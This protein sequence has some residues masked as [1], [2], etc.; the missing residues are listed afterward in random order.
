VSWPLSNDLLLA[1]PVL[2]PLT[3]GVLCALLWS[4]PGAQALVSLLGSAALLASALALSRRVWS[5]GVLATQGGDW[6]AP[7][8]I[9]LVADGLACVM[10][11]IA[12]GTALATSLHAVGSVGDWIRRG[13]FFPL[14]HTLL[15]GVC[16]AFL[17]GDVFN[18]YVWYEV[19]LVS[20]FVLLTLGG[21]RP[22]LEGGLKYLV[23]NLF[24][25]GLF[26]AGV[27]IIYA[28]AGTL[29]MAHLAERF[30]A[31]R[32]PLATAS[33]VLILL[34][35]LMKAAAAPMFFWLPASYPA[36]PPV[37]AALFAGLLSKVGVYSA[38]RTSALF[39]GAEAE[40]VFGA[41]T[42][43]AGATMVLGVFGAAVQVEIRRILA[44][45]SVSQIGYMLMGVGVGLLAAREARALEGLDPSR[46][47]ALRSAAELALAGAVI[48]LVHHAVI[49]GNLFLI[50]GAILR[51]RGT[52][53]L[54]ELGGLVRTRPGLAALFFLTSMSL[55]GIP[56]LSGFV[57]KLALVKAGLQAAQGWVVG[58]ALFT[59]I[60]TLY[61]MVKIWNEAFLKP[62][63]EQPPRPM[64]FARDR[65]TGRPAADGLLMGV[66]IAALAGLGVLMGLLPGP[67]LDLARRAARDVLDP[68]AYT[69]AVLTPPADGARPGVPTARAPRS[70]Q[71][72][73][74]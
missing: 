39:A 11:L 34:A 29:N 26:L 14:V 44:F 6:P 22:Q 61:S 27:G 31:E 10:L 56:L 55:A 60:L 25:S 74:P 7:W 54:A 38:L 64:P 17:T 30:A 65:A 33:G 48:F 71:G 1:L 18:M 21:T 12:G 35:F 13:P 16:G 8:G 36:A 73:V 66:P 49:K 3:T 37:V 40:V 58:A 68:A 50:A 70:E 53:R 24:A 62:P 72:G 43:V 19:L 45:H 5:E 2:I 28:V 9:S 57:A 67:T 23:L 51:D 42:V 4:R 32:P 15:L 41:L 20:S 59:S 52:T 46:A 63:P 69:R 47:A